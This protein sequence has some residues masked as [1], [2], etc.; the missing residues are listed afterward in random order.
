MS[1]T[2]CP[3]KWK[4]MHINPQEKY[5][6]ACC[7]AESEHYN[8]SPDEVINKQKDNLLN[9]IKDSS[10]NFCW[11]PES[12]GLISKR[13]KALKENPS[14]IP[15]LE[16]L[17]INLGNLCNFQCIYCGPKNSSQWNND[18][19]K[20][21]Y[22][23]I[24]DKEHY[25]IT[26][27]NRPSAEEV[28]DLIKKYNPKKFLMFIGGEPLINPII[29]NIIEN[30]SNISIDF[31]TNLSNKAMENLRKILPI[32][33]KR[34]IKI[35]LSVSIDCLGDL[36]EFNRYGIKATD[37]QKHLLEINT[38]DIEVRILSLITA[39]TLWGFTE[40]YN[41]LHKNF[42]NPR[43]FLSTCQRP[44]IHSFAVLTEKEKEE[45]VKILS[46]YSKCYSHDLLI[47]ELNNT[48]FKKMLRI[49]MQ[50]FY[51]EFSKRKKYCNT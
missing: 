22:K 4:N 10:C 5:A 40:L 17:E 14:K 6:Y 23:T 15:D 12:N 13:L 16:L 42:D 28:I 2:F 37:I 48:E 25:S 50:N 46:P 35:H 32:C 38:L 21:P 43:I 44:K 29:F 26:Y 47:S 27:N 31:P 1:D 8:N 30:V 3:L 19:K 39:Q 41:F 18:V 34:N 9:G 36:A 20:E 49:D 7:F 33:K 51:K 45:A 11:I 24:V